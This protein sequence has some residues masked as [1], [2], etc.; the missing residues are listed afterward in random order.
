M[1][2][3]LTLIAVVLAWAYVIHLKVDVGVADQA[4]AASGQHLLTGTLL[5]L[6]IFGVATIVVLKCVPVLMAWY[7][8]RNPPS[9]E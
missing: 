9:N 4:I 6:L 1:A 3:L 7:D 5:P 2:S 8:R